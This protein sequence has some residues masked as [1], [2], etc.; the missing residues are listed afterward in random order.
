MSRHTLFDL[1]GKTAI[2]TG[3]ASGLGLAMAEALAENGARV[4]LA[5]L[6]A[7]AAVQAA[8]NLSAKGYA[9]EG[10]ALD[11]A[12]VAAVRA[13][14]ADVAQ[15]LGRLDIVFANA[16]I[17][18]GPGPFTEQGALG[19]V[20]PERWKQVLD[21][22]L[23]GVFATVEAAAIAMKPRGS[24]RIVVTASTA[25]FRADPMVGYAYVAT[26]AA[27]VNLVKQAAVDLARFGIN[28]NGIAPGPFRTNI[29]GGRMHEEATE[30]LF[31]DSLPIGRI[32][33]PEEIKGPALLLASDASSFMTGAI[34][35][36][37][38]GALAW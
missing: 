19:N 8:A 31:A 13:G 27:V 11:V 37:D 1:S 17:S 20:S 6:R 14:I 36:V 32:G 4:V 3:A 28:V 23:T 30:K 9:A 21:I 15:R 26:K 22:N 5:D 35:P 10:A 12:D 24:G 2:V 34:V 29:G 18:A 16:G 33:T 7:E 38:G 25:G